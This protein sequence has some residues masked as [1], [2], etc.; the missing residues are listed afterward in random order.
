M[1]AQVIDI[2][3]FEAWM[4]GHPTVTLELCAA[5]A[6]VV[7]V[8]VLSWLRQGLREGV[9]WAGLWRRWR[10]EE[11]PVLYWLAMASHALAG[12]C[13]G[14]ISIGTAVWG[15]FLLFRPH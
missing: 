11:F 3:A 15:L 12:V 2:Y 7:A 6:L 10:R 5:L 14:L 4:H 13:L 1:M 9:T 8:F